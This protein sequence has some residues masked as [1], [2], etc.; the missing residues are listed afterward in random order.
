MGQVIGATDHHAAR[1]SQ[2]PLDP[3]DILA[4]I[5]QHW[6]IDHNAE[7]SDPRGRPIPLTRGTLIT[8]LA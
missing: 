8:E 2:R 1:S 3:H 7:F 6:G 4:T 5:Y